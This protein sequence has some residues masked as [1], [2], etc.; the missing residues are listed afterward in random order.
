[1]VKHMGLHALQ[2]LFGVL[3]LSAFIRSENGPEFVAKY[4]LALLQKLWVGIIYTA[5]GSPWQNAYIESFNSI[6][7]DAV[8]NRCIFRAEYN[9][10]CPHAGEISRRLLSFLEITITI[11]IS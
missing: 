8:L 11:T 10:V 1:M 7:R 5:P 6:I 4:I 9:Q 3:G 2:K